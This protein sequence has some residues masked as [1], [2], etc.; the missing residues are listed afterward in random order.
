MLIGCVSTE[1]PTCRGQERWLEQ[2]QRREA[3]AA[4]G[5]YGAGGSSAGAYTRPL[6]SS[7]RAISDTK[8]TLTTPYYPLTPPKR[9]HPLNNL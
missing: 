5:L 2:R 7:T 6:L 8:H 9:P 3:R 1:H 4:A